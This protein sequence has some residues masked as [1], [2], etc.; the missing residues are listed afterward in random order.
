VTEAGRFDVAVVGASAAGCTAARLFAQAG[1]R[2][3]LIEQRPDPGA[4]KV[5]CTHAI[6]PSA[7]PTI[8]RLGL[9]P[10][11]QARGALR[12]KAEVW[13][14]H[15]GWFGFPDDA[16]EG[17]GV[18]RRTLDP[19]LREL[20][21]GT[22]RVELFSGWTTTRLLRDGD[23]VAGVQ[24][25]DRTHR[26][27]AVRARLVV[28]ADGRDS[29]VA[30]LARV[31]GRVRP[32]NRFFYFAYWRGVQP[33]T[34]ANRLWLLDPDGAAQFPNEDDITV[35]VLAPHRSKLDSFRTDVEGAY[36]D[37]LAR[38][39][40]TPDLSRAERI[41]KP[42]GKLDVP[43]VIRPAALATDPLFGVG[44][45]FA[46]QS[47]SWLVDE[48]TAALLDGRA[49]DPA[50]ARYRRRF[51]WRLGPH[52]LQIADYATGRRTRP[53]ERSALAAAVADP[54]VAMALGAVVTR[55]RSPLHMAN[56]RVA[57]HLARRG[58][59]DAWAAVT[60]TDGPAAG[61]WAYPRPSVAR[62]A[63]SAL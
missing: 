59:S 25:E 20:A 39:P 57:S 15:G 8:A 14:P 60:R 27:L 16:P 32:H 2:V 63:S 5:A 33:R 56:P 3:A 61:R 55:E 17:W 31:P 42:I 18:T 44:L 62:S 28:A 11:L 7:T 13:S 43:N 36:A 37:G 53:W 6:L 26:T 50:L 51:L 24:A 10:L 41:S 34:R 21:A 38:L 46:L 29:T 52:H 49:L 30:R 35:L 4:Y 22:E 12:T 48:T 47:A 40:D 54:V 19:M 1:A 45:S 23:R 9:A 58:V